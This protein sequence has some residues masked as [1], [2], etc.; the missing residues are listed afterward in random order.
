[1][2]RNIVGT[3]LMVGTGKL[4]VVGFE[5]ILAVLDRRRAGPTAPAC[6]LCLIEV[7]Y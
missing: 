4:T 6:G 1:M 2:V 7:Q 5:E 3:L